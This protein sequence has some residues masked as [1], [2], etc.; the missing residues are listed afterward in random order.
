MRRIFVSYRRSDTQFVADALYAELVSVYGDEGVFMDIDDIPLGVDFREYLNEQLAE[1]EVML[2]LI[3]PNW[4]NSVDN[5]GNR[6]LE[7]PDDF[8]RVE[9]EAALASKVRVI[10]LY[11]GGVQGIDEKKLPPSL[12]KLPYL[13]AQH[14][15]RGNDFSNDVTHLI[16]NLKEILNEIDGK[17]G[18]NTLA[19]K[20]KK[21]KSPVWGWI[22][23]I[24]VIAVIIIGGIILNNNN[25]KNESEAI[26]LTEST[27]VK[28][29]NTH[30]PTTAIK[31]PTK[32]E[33]PPATATITPTPFPN[34]HSMILIMA[35]E[36]PMG[37]ENGD[38]DESPLRSVFLDAFLIDLYEVTNAQYAAFLNEKGNQ[39]EGDV[40]WLNTTSPDVRIHQTGEKWGA[41]E[42]YEDHPV[43]E[44]TWYGAVTYCQWMGGNLPTEAQWEKAARGTTGKIYPMGPSIHSGAAN[45]DN[46]IGD[47]MPVGSFADGASPYGLYDMAGNVW[48]WTGDWYNDTYYESSPTENPTGPESGSRHVLRGGSWIYDEYYLRTTHRGFRAPTYSSNNLGFRCV[49]DAP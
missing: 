36:F 41:V 10:P 35:G 27:I 1:V 4:L 15:R 24:A 44:V 12:Q 37:S 29:T 40:P 39:T 45:F 3:G 9:V 20:N 11:I 16:N 26:L 31:T 19:E 33:P 48:E 2:L 47:T 22:A 14:I 43:I 21:N 23:S 7:K 46:N 30:T 5:H 38:A 13:N 8:V 34:A 18:S 49:N 32:T 28:F 17:L 6:R 25:K 42:G